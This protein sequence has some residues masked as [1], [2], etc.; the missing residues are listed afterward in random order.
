MTGYKKKR[1]HEI[2]QAHFHCTVLLFK[3]LTEASRKQKDNICLWISLS[4]YTPVLWN[5]TKWLKSEQWEGWAWGRRWGNEGWR[6]SINSFIRW[7]VM[8][9]FFCHV[10]WFWAGLLRML[11]PRFLL[12]KL[13]AWIDNLKVPVSI[14]WGFKFMP[15]KDQHLAV[16]TCP[17]K[18]HTILLLLRFLYISYN[19]HS[20]VACTPN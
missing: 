18:P 16:T 9:F 1:R 13:R 12:C 2:P 14:K 8:W 19:Y 6:H 17:Q 3:L 7:P 10:M 11:S 4:F 20:N 15:S 5:S